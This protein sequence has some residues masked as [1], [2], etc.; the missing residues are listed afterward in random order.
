MLLIIS[1]AVFLLIYGAPG[2]TEQVLLGTR[3]ATPELRASIRAEYGLDDPVLV[4]YWSW[5]SDAL[6]G[7][8]RTSIRSGEPVSTALSDRLVVSAQLAGLAFVFVMA[9][10]LPVG[11]FAAIKRGSWIDRSSAAGAI[12]AASTPAF[13]S[14]ILLL[15]VFAIELGLFP[16]FGL[17]EG[18]VDR[19]RHLT[20]PALALSLA[21]VAM[22]IKMT[23]S[24][25]ISALGQ[26]YV[27]FAR[28]RGISRSGVTIRYALRNALI[29]VTTA[30]G[31]VVAYL[32][33][34]A[35]LVEYTFSIPG[36][37]ML[38]VDSVQGQ[39]IPVIQGLTILI[40]LVI[41][42]INLAVDLLYT[43]I[44]PRIRMGASAR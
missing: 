6:S 29:P 8:L 42:A 17:G 14:G 43:V 9:I 23:R 24:S 2:S 37:G 38:L 39:D 18:F 25:M 40:A 16:T 32:L 3:P 30:S 11:V 19:L 13:V 7:D 34:G 35:V 31:F 36:L 21:T 15:Y 44:D 20:L 12:M 28:A 10:G 33:T 5:L 1:F 26:D 27:V 41:F 22:V 4:Q